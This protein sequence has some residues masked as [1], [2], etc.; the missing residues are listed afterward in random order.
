MNGGGGGGGTTTAATLTLS[1]SRLSKVSARFPRH[2][3]FRERGLIFPPNGVALS[4]R[5]KPIR[6]QTL[7]STDTS[8]KVTLRTSSKKVAAQFFFF[9]QLVGV[10]EYA[11]QAVG[12]A[13]RTLPPLSLSLSLSPHNPSA[14]HIRE[15]SRGKRASTRTTTTTNH[16]QRERRRVRVR[17]TERERERKREER[18]KVQFSAGNFAPKKRRGAAAR[19]RRPSTAHLPPSLSS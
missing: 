6:E 5:Q 14:M 16:R 8:V 7:S 19:S 9:R 18:R 4:K 17:E 15:T 10:E 3:R 11:L 13:P 1:S 12:N 2:L